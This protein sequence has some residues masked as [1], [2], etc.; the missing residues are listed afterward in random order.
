MKKLFLLTTLITASLG[1]SLFG[2]VDFSKWSIGV[3]PSLLQ[4]HNTEGNEFF[5]L[6]NSTFAVDLGVGYDLNSSLMVEGHLMGGKL[7]YAPNDSADNT[8]DSDLFSLNAQLH[9]MFDNGYLLK[10]DARIAPFLFVGAGAVRTKEG[11]GAVVP[12]GGG[13]KFRIDDLFSIQLRSAY[14]LTTRDEYNYLQHTLG[15]VWNLGSAGM[16]ERKPKDSDGDGIV[17]KMDKCP[18]VAGV[19]SNQGCPELVEEPKDSDGDGI[20]DAS[21]RCPNVPGVLANGGC[22]EVKDTDKDGIPDDEDKC[23]NY[24]GVRSNDG[25]PEI[26]DTDKDGIADAN[27][28][29]PNVYGVASN[30]GCPEVLDADKDGIADADDKCPNEYGI[31]ANNGCPEVDEESR[32]VLDLAIEGIQFE[33]GKDIIK[34]ESYGILN[35]VVTIMNTHPAYNLSIEGHTD[36]QGNDAMNLDLSKRRAAAAKTYL[37]N[38]GISSSRITSEGYGETRPRDTNDTSAGR[39]RNRRCELKVVF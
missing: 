14:N 8:F 27:D 3:F 38:K 33:T 37:V 28:K 30:D 32:E 36:S 26:V 11:F 25:C 10:E 16:T 2:Q 9:Y 20:V 7:D 15:F 6:D 31:A 35:R 29:C 39:A 21:D 23:P 13:L 4:Y 1:G 17:D 19:E 24:P 22:P 34:S 18:D 5:D 12:L